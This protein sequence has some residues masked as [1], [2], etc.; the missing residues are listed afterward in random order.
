MVNLNTDISSSGPRA[1]QC[2]V[3]H[4]S[5]KYAFLVFVCLRGVAGRS[6]LSWDKGVLLEICHSWVV[7][8]CIL[9]DV[10]KTSK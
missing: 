3:S 7:V 10:V 6:V 8:V 9:V 5:L 4:F 1:R 2:L